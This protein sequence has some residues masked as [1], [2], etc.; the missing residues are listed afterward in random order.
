MTS[1]LKITFRNI[2]TQ[3]EQFLRLVYRSIRN[4]ELAGVP[5][6]DEQKDQ[7]LRFQFDAQHADYTKNY[8]GAQFLVI[9]SAG[10]GVGRLYVD[11]TESEIHILDIAL[12]QSARG[13]GIGGLILNDL[14][15]ESRT[16]GKAVRIYV[17]N[18]NPALRLYKRLGFKQV[19]K[20]DVYLEML[21]SAA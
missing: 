13:Q 10:E 19:A 2:Q 17:E 3:D 14:I 15:G 5:W 1:D 21:W 6:T 18:F 4:E 16:T 9:E 11:R 7:F 8:P 12:L 20:G